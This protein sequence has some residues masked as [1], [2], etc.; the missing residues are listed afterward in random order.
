MA[1]AHP[2]QIVW[3]RGMRGLA[4]GVTGDRDGALADFEYFLTTG[5][6]SV[7]WRTLVQNWTTALRAGKDP[8]TAE[9]L[10]SLRSP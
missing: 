2:D 5:L 3:T 4:R 7:Q 10:E 1:A 6:G 8:F 9:L